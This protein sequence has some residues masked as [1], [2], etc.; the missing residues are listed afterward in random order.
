[1]IDKSKANPRTFARLGYAIIIL[2]FGGIGG[3]AATARLDSAVI[4]PGVVVLENNRQ[5]VQHLEGGIVSEIHIQEGGIRCSKE[6]SSSR[7]TGWQRVAISRCSSFDGILHARWKPGCWPSAICSTPSSFRE[8]LQESSD[9]Q[10]ASAIEDQIS[11]FESRR[12]VLDS[13]V[14][15]LQARI[16][17]LGE[18]IEG[19]ELQRRAFDRR[20]ATPGRT[21]CQ[22]SYWRTERGPGAQFTGSTGRQLHPAG[23]TAWQRHVGYCAQPLAAKTK[24]RCRS[25]RQSVSTAKEPARRWTQYARISGS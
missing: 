25:S 1:M 13:Q 5:T 4:A 17:Q 23:G 3:W 8:D 24:P 21:A 12:L 6:I 10:V 22:V 20:M 9:P 11:A 2:I 7:W 14:L 19:L 18:Q 16:E 15:V